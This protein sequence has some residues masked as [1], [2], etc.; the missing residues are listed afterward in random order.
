M[1]VCQE[2]FKKSYEKSKGMSDCRA[3]ALFVML[4]TGLCRQNVNGADDTNDLLPV[5][6]QLTQKVNQLQ[7]ELQALRATVEKL[8]P[9][10]VSFS[11]QHTDHYFNSTAGSTIIFDI[12]LINNG[13][14]YSTRHGEFTVPVSGLYHLTFRGWAKVNNEGFLS[15]VR[16]NNVLSELQVGDA[17]EE[18]SSSQSL[19]VHL[20]QGDVLSVNVQ[21]IGHGMPQITLMG[22]HRTTF[23]GY[24]L[25]AD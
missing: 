12:I 2:I 1:Y 8:Q 11:L 4:T 25:Q 22:E 16:N 7:S 17:L 13:G 10:T 9:A 18:D 15:L 21:S 20:T 14:G 5:V 6:T 3:I 24:L 19:L 23:M